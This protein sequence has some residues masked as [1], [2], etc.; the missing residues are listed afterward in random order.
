MKFCCDYHLHTKASDGR[1]TVLS[2]VESARQKGLEE[3]AITDHSFASTIFHMSKNKF[4]K[5]N[6]IVKSVKD[7]VVLQ[8]IEGNLLNTNGDIDVPEDVLERL[9]VLIVGFHRYIGFH[10]TK[11]RA[12]R[13]WIFLNGFASKKRREKLVEENTKAYILA[14]QK[15]PVDVI[16]HLNHRAP[17]DVKR[18]CEAARDSGVYIELNEK[19]V[20]TLSD[21]AQDM[22]DS[23]VNFIV[24]T[25]AHDYKK[26][27]KFDRV[28]EFIKRCGIPEERVYGIDGRRAKFKEKGGKKE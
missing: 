9:D 11:G 4:D 5:Q 19:H 10:T 7:V 27:G 20:D 26:T 1:C 2:H 8:G 12:Q 25:D 14:M 13:S 21:C 6:S 3:I 17:V 24:G 28:A 23:G 18:V 22:I 15:Y 16:T